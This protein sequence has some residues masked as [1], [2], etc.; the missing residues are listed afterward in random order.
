LGHGCSWA[1]VPSWGCV[2]AHVAM[3][4]DGRDVLS[5][6]TPTPL[7]LSDAYT[8]QRRLAGAQGIC[9][10]RCQHP[11]ALPAR[12]YV[13]S[14]R[15]TIQVDYI[16]YM[17]ELACQVGVKP[18]LLTLFLTDPKLALEVAFGPCTPYQYR[19]RGPGAWPGAREA[20]LTQRQRIIKPLQTRHM[21]KQASAHAM[22][23]FFKL[24]GA[25]AVLAV[26]F[27]YL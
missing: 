8:L 18:S 4:A 25:A 7:T 12:R 24:V 23:L 22:P 6:T 26:V 16:P 19:L 9:Q 2:P 27:A 11:P 17:D 21:E 14:Q 10:L 3:P 5:H 15:H 20:I 13:K 1:P